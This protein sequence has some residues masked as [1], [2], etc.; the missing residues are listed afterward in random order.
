MGFFTLYLSKVTSY[1]KPAFQALNDDRIPLKSVHLLRRRRRVSEAWRG[2]ADG[3]DIVDSCGV[4]VLRGV[5]VASI[6]DQGLCGSL[7]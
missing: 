4:G 1:T 2:L 3:R 7:H 5:W 6:V